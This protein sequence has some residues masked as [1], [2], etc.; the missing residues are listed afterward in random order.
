M[1]AAGAALVD[2]GGESTRPGAGQVWEGDELARVM[3][4]LERLARAQ[5]P[6]SID[7]RKAAEIE[8]ALGAGA[9]LVAAVALVAERE[10][11]DEASGGTK[12]GG[13]KSGGSEKTV[14]RGTSGGDEG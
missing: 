10:D 11:D 1:L 7:T 13:A 9:A 14:G 5:A 3:P 4:V 12:K 2:L 6:V 8:A